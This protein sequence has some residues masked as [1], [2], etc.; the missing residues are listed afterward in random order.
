MRVN[1]KHNEVNNMLLFCYDK[2]FKPDRGLMNNQKSLIDYD[3]M[4]QLKAVI[5]SFLHVCMFFNK[6]LGLFS[7]CLFSGI[8]DNT[9]IRW[10][11]EEGKMSNPIRWELIKTV[12]EYN[13]GALIS[14]LKDTPVGALAVANNDVETGLEWSKNQQVQVTANQVF[15]LPSER[16]DKL[17]LDRPKAE[18]LEIPKAD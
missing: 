10:S 14:N 18:P 9:V 7:F 11:S 13:K 2:L 12:K 3:D 4:E 16:T 6:A 15:Y 17:K 5:D 1:I 8:D